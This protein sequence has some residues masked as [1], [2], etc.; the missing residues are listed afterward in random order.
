M[1]KNL[2][3]LKEMKTSKRDRVFKT[4][5]LDLSQKIAVRLDAKTIVYVSKPY[6]IEKLR[7][8]YLKK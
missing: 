5:P 8:K 7:K 2:E 4:K 6:N 3:I 1:G